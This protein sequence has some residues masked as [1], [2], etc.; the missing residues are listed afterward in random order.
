MARFVFAC[1]LRWGDMD[2]FGHV[3]NVAYFSYL[4]ESRTAMLFA[5]PAASAI[6][7]LATGVVVARHEINYRRPLDWRAAPIDIH[8]WVSELRAASFT[9][10]YELFDAGVLIA[11][12]VTV[13]VPFELAEGRPRRLDAAETEF[14]GHFV[15]GA[16]P[17]RS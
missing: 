11:D 12:A 14:L 5:G 2:A 7:R 1:P 16:P 8:V 9:L 3:N 4:E 13:C 6:P 10:S 15:D 17:T